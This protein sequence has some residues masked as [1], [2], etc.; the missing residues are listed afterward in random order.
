[1]STAQ[2]VVLIIEL[3]GISGQAAILVTGRARALIQTL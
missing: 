3:G 2:E 1:L